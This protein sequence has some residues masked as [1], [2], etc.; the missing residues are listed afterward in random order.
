MPKLV[1]TTVG[2]QIGARNHDVPNLK[3]FLSRFGYYS[4][5]PIAH[6]AGADTELFGLGTQL[7]LRRYQRF[8]NLPETGV[9]DAATASTMAMPRCGFPDVA[10]YAVAATKWSTRSLSYAVE[11]TPANLTLAEVRS[12]VEQAFGLWSRVTGLQF[13]EVAASP[14]IHIRFETGDH[15]DGSPFDGAGHVLAHA[16]YPPPNAGDLAGDAHFDD[17]ETWTITVPTTGGAFDLV[18]VAAHELGHS[19]GLAHSAVS[20]A[21][22][23]PTYSGAHRYLAADDVS[24]IQALYGSGFLLQTGTAL[25]ET[26]DTFA[27]LLAPNMDVFAIKKSATGTHSTEVHVL[28]AASN[29]QTF[30]LQTGTCLHETDGT[31]SFGLASNRDLIAIKK[32]ATGSHS[33]EVHV[34]SAASSYQSFVL[35]TGTALHETDDTFAFAVASNRDLIA[36]KKSATGT[37]STEIHVLAGET[38]YQ[39]FKLQTGTALHETDATFA[40]A[41]ASNRDVVAIKKSGTGTNSTEVHVLS[42]ANN[43]QTF[44]L[45]TGTSLHETDANFAFAFTRDRDLMAIKKSATGTHSTEVHIVDLV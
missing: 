25:H 39:T 44:A 32:S 28:S 35:Q 15:H 6:L 45:Q 8:H 33:T 40:F 34:L 17:A 20:G 41:V 18:S 22:M 24:G 36:I 5:G 9:F 19:L 29:Y 2:L 38:N 10:A 12:A 23:Y 4:G 7:A 3:A 30:A 11:N 21:L 42:A 43:Y 31:F 14:D 16:F 1:P 13:R 37:H 27:F 26:D